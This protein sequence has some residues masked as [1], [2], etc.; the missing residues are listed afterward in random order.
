[1]KWIAGV[2]LPLFLILFG[3]VGALVVAGCSEDDEQGSSLEKVSGDD[4]DGETGRELPEPIVIRLHDAEGV[5][6]KGATVKFEVTG[7]GGTLSSPTA[8]TDGEGV[9]SVRWTLGPPPVWNRV[10]ARHGSHEVEFVA[11]ADLGQLPALN[12]V[13]QG[14]AG[15]PSEDLAFE[16]GRGLFLGSP[17][18]ILN[19]AAPGASTVELDLTGETIESAAGIAFGPTGDLYVCENGSSVGTA[20]KRIRP[21]GLC[22]TLS[23]G[24]EDQRFALPNYA[25][26]HSSGEIYL[27]STCDHMIYRISPVDGK[28]TEFIAIPGPNGIAFDAQERYLYILTE[29]P[30]AFCYPGPDIR[31]GL[32]RVP[33]GPGGKAGAVEPLVEDFALAGD[34]L[35]FDEEEN[36]YLVFSGYIERRVGRLF[37]SG[38]FVYTP[39]GRFNEY[40]TVN[41]LEGEIITNIAFGVEPFD[42]HSLYC[43]GFTGRLYRVEVGIRGLP[44]P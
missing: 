27:A 35:A 42:P 16:E 40:F 34:G 30:Q 41:I 20:V 10:K 2:R 17:G 15:I 1:M 44:L 11:W 26:V 32:Y 24:F 37:D 29:N 36:L 8:V 28:T 33:L 31:G 7:G 12:L 6:I 22:E 18:A 38:V 21:S 4:Q 13:F 9:A 25:A 23:K 19:M 14:A 3:V 5:G 43:Y 39:D